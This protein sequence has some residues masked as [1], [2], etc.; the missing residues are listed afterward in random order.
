MKHSA[1]LSFLPFVSFLLLIMPLLAGAQEVNGHLQWAQRVELA[2]PVKGVIKKVKVENG[3][4]VK[5]GE[6]LLQLDQ[7]GFQARVDGL[8]AKG[9]KLKALQDEAGR[10][11]D[12]AL[13]LYDRTVLSEHDLQ[14][15]KI[16][17]ITA[18]ADTRL[19]QAELQQARLDLEYS[20]LRAPFDARVLAR[21]A[22]VGQTVV[23]ELKPMVLIVLADARRMRA[24]AWLAAEQLG[25]LHPGDEAGVVLPQGRVAA[26]IV[27]IGYEP[28]DAAAKGKT[29]G[30]SHRYALTLEFDS[31]D[32]VLRAGMPVK[33]ILP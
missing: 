13:E 5:R 16:A 33:I 12:R 10:E 32:K 1:R 28:R 9:A 19:L 2:T 14:V 31:A 3:S 20:S 6:L 23:A 4:L 24:V 30:E 8:L 25:D 17:F 26:R 29:Q 21:F 11:R 27:S 7:R 15:A 18:N 22:E